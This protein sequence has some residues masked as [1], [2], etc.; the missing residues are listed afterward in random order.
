MT[1]KNSCP[2]CSS[3]SI[4]IF[5]EVANVP[6]HSVLLLETKEKAINYPKKDIKLGFCQKCGFIY[7]TV[8]DP[9]VHEYSSKYEATQS[10]SPT[11]NTFARSLVNNLIKRYDLHNKDMIEIGCGNGE[12]LT[13]LCELGNNRGIGFDPVFQEDRSSSKKNISF[14]KDFYSKKYSNYKADFICCKM[15]LEHISNVFEFVSTVRK[16]IGNKNTIVFFQIPEVRR[17]LR[18][19]AFWDIY[20]EHC[21]YFSLGSLA[22]LFRKCNFDILDLWT[23]YDDQYLMITAKPGSGNSTLA[24]ENDIE[25]LRKD[26]TYFAENSHKIIN[27]W[28]QKIQDLKSQKKR[29]VVWGSSSKGVAFLTTLNIQDEIEYV[30]DI[31]PHKKG[32]YMA[33][34][35][36][37]IVTPDFLKDYKPDVVIL[38]NPIYKEEIKTMLNKI[39]LNPEI[40]TV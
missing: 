29:I 36:Q 18:E 8:F 37:K 28:K 13:L 24:H 17:I 5:Y 39:D 19:I 10:F 1:E 15:T 4:K 26:V 7:N 11:F 2:S 33:G 27:K 32:Y 3:S 31:N 23:D 35:G 20:Y 21:S 38:M 22:R 6:V 40:I 25:A 12:F 9:K 14:I 16:S 30:V 34:A